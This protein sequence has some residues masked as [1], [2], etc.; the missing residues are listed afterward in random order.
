MDTGLE[1]LFDYTKFHIG[2]YLTLAAAYITLATSKIGDTLPKLNPY[3]VW[4]AVIFIIIAGFAGGVIA[5]SIT[6]CGCTTVADF[7]NQ[8]TGP[9]DTHLL[10]GWW[11]TYI[12]HTTFWIGIVCV[13][14]S[15][16]FS[17][18]A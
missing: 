14:L 18:R 9:W 15:F 4:P 5:S 16:A 7:L 2:V 8:S 1:L 3:F 17:E 6:Q 10:T 12:E 11:W 13:V